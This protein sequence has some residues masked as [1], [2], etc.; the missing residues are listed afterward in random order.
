MPCGGCRRKKNKSDSQKRALP[1]LPQETIS[2]RESICLNCP[3]SKKV[4]NGHIRRLGK[5]KK[6]EGR[7][8][9]NIIRD[10]FF[11]CPKKKF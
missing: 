5:C 4:V 11:K 9:I 3:Y 6:S 8:I 10:P 7:S 1:V 2:K